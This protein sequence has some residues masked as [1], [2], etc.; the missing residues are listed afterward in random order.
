MP[1]DDGVVETMRTWTPG[2]VVPT[3]T[4]LTAVPPLAVAGT[5]GRS[6]SPAAR[7]N[8]N[9]AF[10]AGHDATAKAAETAI[11]G[12]KA[13][14][15]VSRMTS[16]L[17]GLRGREK[18]A[19]TEAE[20][21]AP[22]LN[23]PPPP[24]MDVH[25]RLRGSVL[26]PSPSPATC[27]PGSARQPSPAGSGGVGVGAATSCPPMGL[28]PTGVERLGSHY[29]PAAQALYL[30][31]ARGRLAW[32]DAGG[33]GCLRAER[34]ADSGDD[35][36]RGALEGAEAPWV[37]QR[38][39][40]GSL[41][42]S[43]V[44]SGLDS[45]IV[46]SAGGHPAGGK[47]AAGGLPAA[48]TVP[49]RVTNLPSGFEI[50][51]GRGHVERKEPLPSPSPPSPAAEKR[52][53]DR[54]VAPS[55]PR[56]SGTT[57]RRGTSGVRLTSAPRRVLSRAER[58]AGSG[59]GGSEGRSGGVAQKK[60]FERLEGGSEVDNGGGGGSG[61]DGGHGATAV[62]QAALVVKAAETEEQ[63]QAEFSRYSIRVLL[64]SLTTMRFRQ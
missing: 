32:R 16:P 37:Q 27:T 4:F 13:K 15:R 54:P 14:A 38:S 7:G 59:A 34:V 41:R 62:L 35:P 55:N 1:D 29:S 17:R 39:A 3:T 22:T 45:R 53:L 21:A 28:E 9:T 11:A 19:A 64:V 25:A 24:L 40:V 46:A 61:G 60:A 50:V 23:P 43:R 57:P 52:K 48:A 44:W 8:G 42:A 56:G 47:T 10:K 18:G 20:V 63:H 12:G 30:D 49:P 58:E 26:S 31:L 33:A 6:S 5:S 51:D 2:V 36:G